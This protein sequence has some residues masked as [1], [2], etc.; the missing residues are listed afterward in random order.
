MPLNATWSYTA[1]VSPGNLPWEI[2]TMFG[3]TTVCFMVTLAISMRWAIQDCFKSQA[4]V[5]EEK[6]PI[7]PIHLELV[8]LILTTPAIISSMSVVCMIRPSAAFVLELLMAIFSCV[9]VGNMTRYFLA[10]L[11]E[12]PLPQQLLARVPKRRWWCGCF[13]GGVNDTLPGMGL[14]WS[15]TPHRVTLVD[16]HRATC[17]VR[18]FMT[19]FIAINCTQLSFSMVPVDIRKRPDG[20]CESKTVV[21]SGVISGF[22]VF[23]TVWASFVGMAGFS[24]VASSVSSVLDIEIEILEGNEQKLIKSFKVGSQSKTVAIHML[25]PLLLP[26]LSAMPIGFKGSTVSVAHLGPNLDCPVYDQEVCGHVMYSMSIAIGMMVV[27]ILNYRSF[28]PADMSADRIPVVL[29][30]LNPPSPADFDEHDEESQG[31]SVE[32]E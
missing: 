26:I 2:C 21:S 10:L 17:M 6:R 11:G 19:V 13:C 16:I 24:V 27:S 23:F 22:V 7:V 8:R 9:V 18:I 25:L 31:S 4:I 15:K 12:P 30:Q 5:E 1:F 28:L 3:V 14:V 29:A 20:W 32:S